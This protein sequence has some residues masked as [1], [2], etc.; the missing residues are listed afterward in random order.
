MVDRGIVCELIDMR[1]RLT[2]LEIRVV[3]KDE[4]TLWRILS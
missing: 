2:R 3:R 1:A 4:R